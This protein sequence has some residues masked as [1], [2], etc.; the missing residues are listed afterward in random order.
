MP[1]INAKKPLQYGSAEYRRIRKL[2]PKGVISGQHISWGIWRRTIETRIQSDFRAG[3][4][5]R[6][7]AAALRDKKFVQGARIVCENWH[8]AFD[9]A[10]QQL[11]AGIDPQLTLQYTE[12][13][14]FKKVRAGYAVLERLNELSASGFEITPLSVLNSH[15][16]LYIDSYKHFGGFLVA[17]NA[18]KNY[19]RFID[20]QKDKASS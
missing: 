10:I 13:K 1:R 3:L 6:E 9:G 4:D 15:P 19:H 18:S 11:L 12:I 7:N 2:A 17:L 5:L 8:N 14:P 20:V 16:Q